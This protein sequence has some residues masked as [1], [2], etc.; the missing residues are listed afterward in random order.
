MVANRRDGRDRG[1]RAQGARAVDRGGSVLRQREA[2]EGDQEAEKEHRQAEV[3]RDEGRVEA[4]LDGQ[5]AEPRL[6]EDEDAGGDRPAH[7]PA[8]VSKSPERLERESDDQH[9]DQRSP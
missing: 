3:G 6:R 4:V 1:G 9:H 8:A 7:Q 5:A 2:A